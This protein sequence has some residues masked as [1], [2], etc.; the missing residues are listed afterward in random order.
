VPLVIY[1]I[2]AEQ[3]IAKLF[4][5]AMIPGLIAMIGY[6]VAI[7]IYVRVVPGQAPEHDD[8]APR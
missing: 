7:A 6:M 8:D 4:A 5:A 3:N 2:L 1:A